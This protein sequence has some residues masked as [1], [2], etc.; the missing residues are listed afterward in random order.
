V[1]ILSK[2]KFETMTVFGCVGTIITP[3]L[4]NVGVRLEMTV[5]HGFV[6]TGV[7]AFLTFERF[8]SKMIP[9]VILQVVFVLCHEGTVRANQLLLRSDMSFRMF[10]KL[11]L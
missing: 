4:I 11:N 2:V 7:I 6:D 9:Q 8:A 5:K 1:V 3:V 10:P